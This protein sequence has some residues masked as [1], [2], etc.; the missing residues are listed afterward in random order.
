MGSETHP[1]AC[2]ILSNE[3]SIP[4]YS[5]SNGYNKE[6]KDE[7]SK[8]RIGNFH[9]LVVFKKVSEYQCC[10]W[11]EMQKCNKCTKL[12]KIQATGSFWCRD[13]TGFWLLGM[14]SLQ[15]LKNMHLETQQAGA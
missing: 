6:S 11:Q 15:H 5:T 10:C 9:R 1:F 3:C 2:Y 13:V 8:A 12:L 14:D 4:F 7:V